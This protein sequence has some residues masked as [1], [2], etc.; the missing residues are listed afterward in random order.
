MRDIRN[1]L[2]IVLTILILSVSTGFSQTQLNDSTLKTKHFKKLAKSS[3][4]FGDTYSAIDF[5]ERYLESKP[6]DVKS[7]YTLAECYRATRDYM[8]A[9]RMYKKA[10]LL[11]SN[12]FKKAQYYYALMKKMNGEYDT[13]KLLFENF[14]PNYKG[15]DDTKLFKEQTNVEIE[16][17]KISDSLINKPLNIIVTHLDTTINRGHIELSPMFFQSSNTMIYG[18]LKTDSVDYYNMDN[19]KKP[20]AKFYLAQKKDNVWKGGY[21]YDMFNDNEGIENTGNGVISPDGKRFYFTKC[22]ADW[23]NKIK[24]DIYVSKKEYGNWTEPIKLPKSINHPNYTST[25]PAIGI[26]SKSGNDILYFVTD[27]PK[28][29]GSLDIWYSVYNNEK[30]TYKDPK[31]CGK[32]INTTQ[33][34]ITPFYHL[35]S[36][37]LFYSTSGLPGLGGLDVFKTY[38][39]GKSWSQPT[40]FGYPISSSTDDLYFVMDTNNSTGFFVSNRKGGMSLKNATCCDDIYSYKLTDYFFYVTFQGTLYKMEYLERELSGE[41]IVKD[42]TSAGYLA[43]SSIISLFE[44]KGSPPKA[45]L[46]DKDTSDI[47]G[48][49]HFRVEKNKN[50]KLFIK[51]KDCFNRQ[52]YFTTKEVISV[53]T[54]KNDIPLNEINKNP[55]VI[56]NIYYPFDEYYLTD[57]AKNTIDTTIFLIMQDNPELVVELSSHTDSKGTDQY[58]ITLSQNRAE[59]VV[60]YLV[61]KGINKKQLIAKGYGETKHIY[62]NTNPDGSDNP[63]GRQMNR[64][65][66][67]KV[68]GR[69]DQYSKIIYLE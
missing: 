49:F 34:D 23:Q 22:K 40:N 20:V 15:K 36:N 53:D 66:E 24:C 12:Q 10:Y 44:I 25:Q 69:L 45:Y 19:L 32:T 31:S 61:K 13:S 30:D 21:P 26:D 59:S 8:N 4:R 56:R 3:L 28:S 27:R 38:G 35:G 54:I 64:R 18:S 14:I 68:V 6:E 60:N 5:F 11:D 67:F 33:D 51:S 57:E 63:Q 29:I 16:G 62:P 52:Y 9:E 43:D 2:N 47:N 17:C 41:N 7:I 39:E 50:Y 65:T 37:A 55:I 46:I 1:I 58:N 42:S 48:Q